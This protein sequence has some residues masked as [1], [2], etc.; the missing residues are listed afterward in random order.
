MP[1]ITMVR[2]QD[3]VEHEDFWNWMHKEP[4]QPQ[5]NGTNSLGLGWVVMVQREENGPWGRVRV[6]T[7][8]EGLSKLERWLD[9]EIWDV[10]LLNLRREYPPP[11]LGYQT[12]KRKK[13][14]R[15]SRGE[16]LYHTWERIDVPVRWRWPTPHGERWCPHCRRPTKFRV[17]RRH[18]A[19]NCDPMM[20]RIDLVAEPRCS[21]CGIRWGA[22]TR[23]ARTW[24]KV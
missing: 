13:A 2:M 20:K 9:R 15:N 7:Y 21:V 4:K 8:D 10:A 3:L 14:V 19:I 1:N 17:F 6:E 18:P 24:T 23:K 22:L 12:K 5:V 11:L 16:L